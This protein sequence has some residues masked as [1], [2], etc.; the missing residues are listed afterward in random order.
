MSSPV[1]AEST[2]LE[3]WV[4]TLATALDLEELAID[5]PQ[6]LE[7]ARIAAHGVTRPA[8]PISTF[9][10]GYVLAHQ[11]KSVSEVTAIIERLLTP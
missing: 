7:L 5:I 11:G 10:A 6:L 3:T 9:F 1:P 8:A 2:E 4:R